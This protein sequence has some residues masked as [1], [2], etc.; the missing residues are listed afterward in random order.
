MDR[1]PRMTG[2]TPYYSQYLAHRLTLEGA[3][4]DAFAK[5]LSTARVDLNPYQV[6]AALFALGSPISKGVILADEVGLGKTIEASLV[7]AQRWAAHR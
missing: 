3:T 7:I 2:F 6:D 4:D 5:S 1:C